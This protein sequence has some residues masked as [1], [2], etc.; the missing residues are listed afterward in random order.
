MRNF[1]YIIVC[2]FVFILSL[3]AEDKIDSEETKSFSSSKEMLASHLER[4]KA[5]E[6]RDSALVYVASV[7]EALKDPATEGEEKSSKA[8]V[9]APFSQYFSIFE[10]SL[11]HFAHY[12]HCIIATKM[13]GI[14]YGYQYFM[15][16][17]GMVFVVNPLYAVEETFN[18]TYLR[19]E[20]LDSTVL[21]GQDQVIFFY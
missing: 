17:A 4:K 3:Q 20:Y 19:H 10:G 1:A 11:T 9:V 2:S 13:S 5:E 7:E 21:T 16:H 8:L 12:N 18:G 15:T 14:Q 6:K